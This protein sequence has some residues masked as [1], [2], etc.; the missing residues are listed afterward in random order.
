VI[1]DERHAE[2]I[3]R[4][5]IRYYHGRPSRGLPMQAPVLEHNCVWPPMT[6]TASEQR[7]PPCPFSAGYTTNTASLSPDT[8]PSMS[9]S[10]ARS[11]RWLG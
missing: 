1:G 8:P 5:Y 4:E 6:A 3:L 9:R 10:L 7:A 11:N 2:R